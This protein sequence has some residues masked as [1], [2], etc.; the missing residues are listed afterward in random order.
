[1]TTGVSLTKEEQKSISDT[2]IAWSLKKDSF[3]LANFTTSLTPPRTRTWLYG[4]ADRHDIIKEALEIARENLSQRYVNGSIDNTYSSF[5]EKY[6]PIYDKEYKALKQWLSEL[7][8]ASKDDSTV[9]L[10][11]IRNMIQAGNML[12][13]LSQPENEKK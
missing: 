13:A 9:S 7:N 8:R 3:H 5:A 4:M 12:K 11:D 2:L 6:L 1:M 10:E